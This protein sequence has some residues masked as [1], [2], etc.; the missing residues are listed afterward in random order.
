M[1]LS[2]AEILGLN[3]QI[4]S[5]EKGK[6]A[7]LVV[8]SGDIFAKDSAVTHVFVDGKKFEMPKKPK[9]KAAAKTGDGD[10]DAKVLNV[11]GKWNITIDAP[12]QSIDLTFDFEQS[13]TSLTGTLNAPDLGGSTPIRNGKVTEDGFSFDATVSFQGTSLEINVTGT[14]NGDSV[15]G[16]VGTAMGPAPFSGKKVPGSKSEETND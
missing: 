4:G 8:M 7:N 16:S 6:I 2:S 9:K 11:A 5:I 14:V 15:E 12:G 13:G 3:N 10:G 1:T